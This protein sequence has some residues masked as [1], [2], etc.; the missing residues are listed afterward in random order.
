MFLVSPMSVA[1][2][3]VGSSRGFGR[4]LLESVLGCDRMLNQESQVLFILLTTSLERASSAFSDAFKHTQGHEFRNDVDSKIHAVIEQVDLFD[5]RECTRVC[6]LLEISLVHHR[7]PVR[8][9]YAFLNSGSVE[10]VGPLLEDA[11]GMEEFIRATE[12][13]C[14]LNFVS[15]A[16]IS[17]T[18]ANYCMINRSVA[19]RIVNISSLAAIQELYGMGVYGAIKAARE[20]FTRSMVLEKHRDGPDVDL[21]F[22]SYAPGPMLTDI[23]TE[24]LISSH[25]KA[26]HVKQTSTEFVDPNASARRCLR[27]L[28]GPDTWASGSHFDYFDLPS[29]ESA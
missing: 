7:Y 23:V 24:S 21:K 11:S 5:S 29:A 18:I 9:I 28:T 12:R 10:P 27:L 4:A 13:H 26:N 25:S 17:R 14:K 15:F 3:I 6:K 16:A 19:G 22:L 2:I 8:K 20:S 1:V